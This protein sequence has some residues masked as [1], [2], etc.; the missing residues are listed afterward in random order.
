MWKRFLLAGLL[1][2]LLSAAATTTAALEAVGQ[3]AHNIAQSPRLVIPQLTPDQAGD[4]QTI[5]VIGSDKRARSTVAQDR[6]SPAHTDTLLLVRMDPGKGQTSIMSIPRDL[7]VSFTDPRTGGYYPN[8]KINSAYSYGG[9][10]LT[11]AVVKQTLG[12]PINHVIDLNF[13]AFRQVVDAIGCVYV[14]VDHRYFNQNLGTIATDYSNINLQPGY[15]KLCDQNALDYVRY[16]HTDSDFVRVAR[17][18]DFIRQV[19]EQV[20]VRGLIDNYGQ[21]TSAFGRAIE[22]DIRGTTDVLRMLK[23]AAFSLSRPIRQVKFQVSSANYLVAGQSFVT[24]TPYDI[25]QTVSDFLHGNEL[26]R[27]PKSLPLATGGGRRHRRASAVATSAAALGLFPT[28]PF[29]RDRAL[30]GAAHVPLAV[31]FPALKTGAA[32]LGDVHTYLLADEQGRIHHGYRIDWQ[33]TGLGG[34]YGIEGMTWTDP[35]L[36]AHPSQTRY[37]GGREYLFVDDG[38]HYHVIAWRTPHALYWVS[39]TLLEDL[40]NDQMLAIAQSAQPLH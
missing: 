3:V 14:D 30:S 25:K 21:I 11:L 17:Q 8:V 6:T 24:A 39:N 20:G 36:I 32:I 4:P 33:Q 35:P 28:Q 23:L 18:Q 16:R 15:Q 34:Y 2:I 13:A 10:S 9:A 31:D 38:S 40:S 27:A 26:A 37:I 5:L 7:M 1:I 22:T 29:E 19:K 12:T